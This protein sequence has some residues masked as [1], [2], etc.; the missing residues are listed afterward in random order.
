MARRQAPLLVIVLVALAAPW[1]AVHPP[2][3]QH[4]DALFAPPVRPRV[5]D[6]GSLHAPFVYP[7]RLV[8]PLAR[9]YEADVSRRVPLRWLGE[10]RLVTAEGW[11]PLGTDAL[12]RDIWSRLV[13]GA[14]LSLGIALVACL[15]ALAVGAAVGGLAGVA[16][17][18]AEA[19][20]MRL[21]EM[22]LVLP[23]LYILLI[24]RA[25]L[26][27]VLPDLTVFLFVA[28]ALALVG[29]PS[30][31]RVVRA[32]VAREATLDY[33]AAAVAAGAG[34][35][36]LLF[37]HLLP[38]ALPALGTQALLLAPAFILAEATLSYVGLGFM[39]P[40]ASWG[41]MLQEAASVR[42]IADYPWVLAPALAIALVVL[43]LNLAL[44]DRGGEAA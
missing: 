30:V 32:V 15:G 7:L 8:D 6:A 2:A 1:L 26:P 3:R 27:L 12:G 14:R 29:W 20:L 17:G 33:A 25:A 41:T 18:W 11:Y 9:Q 31:A 22:V 36:R 23:A 38:A 4:R 35:G 21:S 43:A 5:I 28:G 16:G 39:P 37:K 34:R 44:G 42:A 13:T 40:A 10:G 19:A 24:L